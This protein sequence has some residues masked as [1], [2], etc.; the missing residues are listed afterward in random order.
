MGMLGYKLKTTQNIV[1]Y[2][3]NRCLSTGYRW[4]SNKYS[5]NEL[6]MGLSERHKKIFYLICCKKI[7][8]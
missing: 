6:D 8:P 7:L 2:Q 4:I 5:N 3:T 1:L